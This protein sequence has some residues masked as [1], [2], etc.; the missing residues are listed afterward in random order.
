MKKRVGERDLKLSI[1]KSEDVSR[2]KKQEQSN[3]R[4]C[5]LLELTGS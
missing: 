2:K 1:G 3:L 5:E 4:L